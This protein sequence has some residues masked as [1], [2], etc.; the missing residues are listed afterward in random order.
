MAFAVWVRTFDG[1][2]PEPRD[3]GCVS[4][5]SVDFGVKVSG[6]CEGFLLEEFAVVFHVL[7]ESGSSV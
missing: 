2:G 3:D 5:G 7:S 4:V 6:L 1:S